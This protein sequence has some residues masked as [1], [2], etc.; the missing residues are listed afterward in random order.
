MCSKKKEE[1]VSQCD[2]TIYCHPKSAAGLLGDT[3]NFVPAHTDG[4]YKYWHLNS[5]CCTAKGRNADILGV[6]TDAPTC[7]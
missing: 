5:S 2:V 3:R 4:K 7:A 6:D 1:K